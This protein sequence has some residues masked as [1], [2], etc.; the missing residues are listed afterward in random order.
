LKIVAKPI[1]GLKISRLTYD[2]TLAKS[3][4]LVNFLA[5]PKHSVTLQTGLNIKIEPTLMRNPMLVKPLDAP[6]DT[7]ILVR[8]ENMS[9]L[10]MVMSSM[11]VKDIKVIT[12]T[13][14]IKI[15]VLAVLKKIIQI[16]QEHHIVYQLS[17]LRLRA[18]QDPFL[19]LRSD[20][21]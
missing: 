14:K 7:Q 19:H 15:V 1:Q 10:F 20:T 4:I 16:P 5:V 6:K 13:T 3:P 12:M 11:P 18:L 8:C 2:L 9:K 21:I 17:N